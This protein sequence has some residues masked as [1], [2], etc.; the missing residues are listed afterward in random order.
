M[1]NKNSALVKTWVRLI[2][3]GKYTINDVP[4]ISNLK[5]MVEL[6]LEEG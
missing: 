4:Q 3:G 1:F 5:E 6:A 2:K